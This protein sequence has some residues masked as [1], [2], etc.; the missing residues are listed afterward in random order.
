M[1]GTGKNFGT[2][3]VYGAEKVVESTERD[4]D[5]EEAVME[6]SLGQEQRV[7]VWSHWAGELMKKPKADHETDKMWHMG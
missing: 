4:E 1:E 6:G 7:Q 2:E 5:E 3:N